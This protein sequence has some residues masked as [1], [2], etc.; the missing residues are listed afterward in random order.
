MREIHRSALVPYSPAQMFDLVADVERYPEFLPW[1]EHAEVLSR[2]GEQV[3]ARLGLKRAGIAAR[4][5]TVN[6]LLPG[7]SLDMRLLDGPFKAL[8]G[9]WRFAAIG[10]AGSRVE[11]EMRF[12]TEGTLTGL[13]LAPA[14]ESACN[15]LVDAFG[16]RA[17]SIYG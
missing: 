10:T 16:R 6:R 2:Q 5:T 11:L 1:C 13:V 15:Q 7:E 4:F 17:R 12:Q 3:T 8:E 9:R 14:F